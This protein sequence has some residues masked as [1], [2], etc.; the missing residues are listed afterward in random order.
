M[1]G[2]LFF[3]LAQFSSYSRNHEKVSR[4]SIQGNR[5]LPSVLPTS[6][7]T[8]MFTTDPKGEP[9]LRPNLGGAHLAD[10]W[11]VGSTVP[12]SGINEMKPCRPCD[13]NNAVLIQK[14]LH[15]REYVDHSVP[16][17]TSLGDPYCSFGCSEMREAYSTHYSM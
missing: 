3:G 17:D 1:V 2:S 6:D 7:N 9:S 5:N 11:N 14:R 10:P 13:Q 16:R 4:L 8:L 12:V 15:E